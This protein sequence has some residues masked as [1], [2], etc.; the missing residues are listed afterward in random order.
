MSETEKLAGVAN[1]LFLKAKKNAV[2]QMSLY[3]CTTSKSIPSADVCPSTL[4]RIY[5]LLGIDRSDSVPETTKSLKTSLEDSQ[6]TF[7]RS[8]STKLF[9]GVRKVKEFCK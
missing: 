5:S 1:M 4:E 9:L 8:R 3:T 7:G 6:L 2:R